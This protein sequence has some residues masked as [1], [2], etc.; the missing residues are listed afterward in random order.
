MSLLGDRGLGVSRQVER[1]MVFEN[2][3]PVVLGRAETADSGIECDHLLS[4]GVAGRVGIETAV[5]T[6]AVRQ[7][8]W[9]P[10]GIVPSSG[11]GYAEIRGMQEKATHGV[12]GRFAEH[13]RRCS[14]S[15]D[16]EVAEI[17]LRTRR[18]ATPAC[19]SG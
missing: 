15:G 6:M 8:W 7:E 9:Q 11:C 17:F 14:R 5:D 13:D 12:D 10:A 19:G 4:H 1:G 18:H 2:V 16:G 3:I